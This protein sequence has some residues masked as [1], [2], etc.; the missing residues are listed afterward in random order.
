MKKIILSLLITSIALSNTFAAKSLKDLAKKAL[1]AAN[2]QTEEKPAQVALTPE[3]ALYSF[4][5]GT[6]TELSDEYLPYAMVV[7]G[8]V[9]KKYHNDPFEWEEQFS[10]LKKDFDAKVQT[11]NL[12]QEYVLSTTIEFGDYDFD[13]QG[14]KVSISEGTYFP[15]DSVYYSSMDSVSPSSDS[16][17]RNGFGLKIQDLNKYN[18]IAMDKNSAKAF[19]QGRK[20]YNGN[21][22]KKITILLKYKLAAFDSKEYNTFAA[23]IAQENKIPLVGIIQ[24]SI[25][26]YDQ[27]DNYK[28][29]GE[30]TIK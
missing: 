25:E 1:N 24:G 10:K 30:L 13:A 28:K 17:F 20:K 26:V 14:Y 27:E 9:Y 11:A 21:I 5:K 23:S 15:M 4:F 19:L 12:E 22:Y 29:I 18:F 3:L 2:G 8:P 6:N 16:Y 7:E